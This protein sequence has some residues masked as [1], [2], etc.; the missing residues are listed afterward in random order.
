[1]NRL[2]RGFLNLCESR[3]HVRDVGIASGN[4]GIIYSTLGESGL[5]GSP[6]S[7]SMVRWVLLSMLLHASLI[8]LIEVD[9]TPAFSTCS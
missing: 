1:M 8:Q 9:F 6:S 3:M 7:L 4:N 2:S 5:G